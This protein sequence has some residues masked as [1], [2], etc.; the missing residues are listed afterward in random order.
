MSTIR[1]DTIVDSSG[2][3]PVDFETI[4]SLKLGANGL[5]LNDSAATPHKMID[6]SSAPY[7]SADS[8]AYNG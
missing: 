7:P 3:G 5:V 1:V 6:S 2:S 8:G 4:G